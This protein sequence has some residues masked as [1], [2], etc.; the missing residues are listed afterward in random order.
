MVSH[1]IKP[2]IVYYGNSKNCTYNIMC[3]ARHND[4]VLVSIISKCRLQLRPQVYLKHIKCG[5][6][7]SHLSTT[8][9]KR[10]ITPAAYWEW[11][12]NASYRQEN[13]C[14]PLS[15]A[16]SILSSMQLGKT[17]VFCLTIWWIEPITVMYHSDADYWLP[18]L[19]PRP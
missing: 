11:L 5:Y 8:G 2:S 18:F 7:I 4:Y 15:P 6:T 16:S 19:C 12:L 1:C 17:A 9:L 3:H 10:H 14:M 13:V